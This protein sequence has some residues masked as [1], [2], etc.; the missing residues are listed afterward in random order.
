[1]YFDIVNLVTQLS[2]QIQ[3]RFQDVISNS[4][5]LS[6][7]QALSAAPPHPYERIKYELFGEDYKFPTIKDLEIPEDFDPNV[8]SSQLSGYV[9]QTY[10][11][12]L[13]GLSSLDANTVIN[14][15]EFALPTSTAKHNIQFFE[16]VRNLTLEDIQN[17]PYEVAKKLTSFYVK[18]YQ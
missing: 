6:S 7:L 11:T 5:L 15:N 9:A 10:Q 4:Q 1:M 12:T 18:N 2:A 3:Q 13:S 17:N 16:I 14:V 8:Y